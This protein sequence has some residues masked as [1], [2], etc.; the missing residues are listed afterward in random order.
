MDRANKARTLAESASRAKDEFRAMLGHELRN[1]LGAIAN[2]RHILESPHADTRAIA[3][4]KAVI[5]RQVD[6][7]SRMTDDLLD[8]AR[9]TTSK[10]VLQRMAVDL[11]SS[12]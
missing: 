9:S 10:I 7:L 11:A 2:A 5:G 1:P 3:H 12:A 6:H 8:A 4:A